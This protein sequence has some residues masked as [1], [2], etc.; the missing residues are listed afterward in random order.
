VRLSNQLTI[1]FRRETINMASLVVLTGRQQGKRLKLPLRELVIGRDPAC[2]VTLNTTEVSRRHCVLRTTED[3]VFV[4]DLGSRNSTLVNDVPIPGEVRLKAGD[5]LRIGPVAFQ[6]NESRP[7]TS[8]PGPAGQDSGGDSRDITEDSIASWL[9]DGAGEG[10]ATDSTV[11][12]RAKADTD[13]A[14]PVTKDSDSSSVV[15]AAPV[16]PIPESRP[17]APPRKVFQTVADEAQDI[18]R[19][20]K[21]LKSR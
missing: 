9:A 5:T 15:L 7:A 1:C 16:T 19:R 21:E 4:R 17:A 12:K 18:I 3:G 20:H 8:L 11:I 14:V 6:F 10:S 2:D 13:L